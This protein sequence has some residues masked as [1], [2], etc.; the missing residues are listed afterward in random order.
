MKKTAKKKVRVKSGY[1]VED[2]SADCGGY[3]N[4]MDERLTAAQAI[5]HFCVEC[6]GGH[7]FDW[8]NGDGSVIKKTMT[9]DEVETCMSTKCWLYPNRMGNRAPAREKKKAAPAGA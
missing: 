6:Q 4:L 2:F 5:K 9:Y 3:G 1:I 8:R 7:Y